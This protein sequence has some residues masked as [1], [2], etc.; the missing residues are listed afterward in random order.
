[1][2]RFRCRFL[3]GLPILLA[4]GCAEPAADAPSAVLVT[5]DT[6]RADSFGAG[7]HPDLRT[8][9]LDRVFRGGAQFSEAYS[10]IP[11]TLASHVSMLTGA[12]PTDHGVPRNV[13]RVPD[14]LTSIAE[15]ARARGL[16]TG[17]F[18]SSAVLEADTNVRQGFDVFDDDLTGG[19]DLESWRRAHVTVE[20]ARR[21]WQ[22]TSGRKFLWLHVF[23]P[24]LPYRPAR[25]D[26]ALYA[27]GSGPVVA[28]TAEV[29]S[30]WDDKSKFTDEVV[31]HLRALYR[32]EVTGVDRQ[33]GMFL[34]EIAGEPEVAL[35]VTSDHGE[36]LGEHR[37]FFKHGPKVF[38]AD[39]RVPLLLRHATVEAGVSR[40]LVRTIDVPRTLLGLL[41]IEAE[42]PLDADDLRDWTDRD[43]GLTVFG[44]GS[45][46]AD[47][48]PE[49]FVD[50]AY[51]NARMPRVIRRGDVA[52]LET[53]WQNRRVWYDR[54]ID[55]DEMS[56]RRPAENP[57]IEGMK[58]QLDAWVRGAR[59]L[60]PGLEMDPELEERMRALGYVN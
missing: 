17:A 39:V 58:S 40:A 23:E 16:A 8:P 37:L 4:A 22:D 11:T 54:G 14:D 41:E 34:R 19:P 47:A 38:P 56:A 35:I 33:L 12:W 53:P 46:P 36:S 32:A 50:G 42:L 26:A 29:S 60:Q 49:I 59:V 25:E 13:W 9:H 3:I 1:V 21:W 44:I 6:W 45:A 30:M 52:F 20:R 55:P 2:F 48:P 27:G 51:A 15:I 28:T 10:P 18:I 43:D 31:A 7:G 57:E 24:H 5:I